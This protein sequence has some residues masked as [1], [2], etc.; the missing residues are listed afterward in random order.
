MRCDAASGWIRFTIR[1]RIRIRMWIWI[2][3]QIR[4]NVNQIRRQHVSRITPAE[5]TP[6]HTHIERYGAYNEWLYVW[7]PY[8]AV[9]WVLPPLPLL[10]CFSFHFYGLHVASCKTTISTTTRTNRWHVR[11]IYYNAQIE[12]RKYRRHRRCVPE[13]IAYFQALPQKWKGSC[14]LELSYCFWE[15]N[16]VLHKCQCSRLSSVI[17][18]LQNNSNSV[19]CKVLIK[20]A[21]HNLLPRSLNCK[22]KFAQEHLHFAQKSLRLFGVNAFNAIKSCINFNYINDFMLQYLWAQPPSARGVGGT[23]ASAHSSQEGQLP[24]IGNYNY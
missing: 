12:I 24:S 11:A 7:N 5:L 10:P 6:I 23:W 2:R 16:T 17:I 4:L 21:M 13:G 1:I 20:P 19:D 3:F 22:W 18:G 8:N 15:G 14:K 9:N